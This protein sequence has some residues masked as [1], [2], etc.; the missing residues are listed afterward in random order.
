MKFPWKL[1]G[2]VV[3]ACAS[4]FGA[5]RDEEG[6]RRPGG[7]LAAD[8]IAQDGEMPEGMARK[9]WRAEKL[10]R[11]AERLKPVVALATRWAYCRHYVILSGGLQSRRTLGRDRAA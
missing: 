2:W 11:R 10:A 1:S 6:P 3:L 7:E 8:W 5:P 9:A 4:V